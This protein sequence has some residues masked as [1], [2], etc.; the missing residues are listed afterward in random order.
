M[1]ACGTRSHPSAAARPRPGDSHTG[2]Q[3]PLPSLPCLTPCCYRFAVA[4]VEKPQKKKKKDKEA[5]AVADGAQAEK[6][7]K[8]KKK[9]EA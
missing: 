8:K 6:P 3:R 1:Y 5:A 9:V 2:L 7:K 4:E